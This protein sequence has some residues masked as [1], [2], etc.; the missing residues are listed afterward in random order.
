MK[1]LRGYFKPYEWENHQYEKVFKLT[2]Y[3]YPVW[4]L[5][6]ALVALLVSQDT[7]F[8][9]AVLLFLLGIIIGVSGTLAY[10]DN[11]ENKQ[12]GVK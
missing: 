12:K 2:T 5:A 10:I 7:H 8:W 1:K 6:F 4:V 11:H 3:L 9:L